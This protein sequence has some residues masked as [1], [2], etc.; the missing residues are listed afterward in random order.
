[1][2]IT[3]HFEHKV[4]YFVNDMLYLNAKFR[5][6]GGCQKAPKPV[7]VLSSIF[8]MYRQGY[9]NIL[10]MYRCV[11]LLIFRNKLT[12]LVFE[13]SSLARNEHLYVLLS[14]CMS[15]ITGM[16]LAV[17]VAVAVATAGSKYSTAKT[18]RAEK[19]LDRKEN[20]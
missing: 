13:Q 5:Q 20:D 12:I 15:I 16:K 8:V 1:M 10:Y 3:S 14:T 6:G 4:L 2:A 19:A 18:T 7:R 11:H 17:A 9:G